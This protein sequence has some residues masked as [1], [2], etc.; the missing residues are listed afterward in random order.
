LLALI[1]MEPPAFFQAEAIRN[2]RYKLFQSIRPIALSDTARGQYA[3]YR[4]ASGVAPTS[5]TPTFAVLKLIV[6]NWRWQGVPFYLRSG[7]ALAAKA[8]EIVV[9]FKR[10]PHLGYYL[11][12]KNDL[13]PNML[14]LCIQPDE[15]AHLRFHVKAPDVTG[16]VR[17]VDMEFHYRDSFGSN[18]PDAYEV[19][20]LDALTGDASLFNRSDSIQAAWALIDPILH[21][22]EA[23]GAPPLADYAQGSWGPAQADELIR[24][25][26]RQ[27]RLGCLEHVRAA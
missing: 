13:E 16:D 26:G 8:T 14:S 3:G 6:D 1:A 9:V 21:G 22:W 20:L 27:W 10:P 24:R 7:K 17:P 4:D 12:G 19:L 18:L 23:D 2:E 5:S 11:A 15:G 25:D